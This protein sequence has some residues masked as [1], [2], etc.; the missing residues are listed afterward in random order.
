M[1]G[2][3]FCVDCRMTLPITQYYKINKSHHKLCKK[4]HNLTRSKYKSTSSYKRKGTGFKK[5]PID[6]Q[7]LI[8]TDIE[9]KLEVTKICSKLNEQGIEIKYA[10][11]AYWKR[12]NKIH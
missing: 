2:S 3:K 9:N 4:C 10:T 12:N 11:L 1:E 8:I 5:L 7:E 6:V